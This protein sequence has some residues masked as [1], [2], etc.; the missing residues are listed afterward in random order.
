M[1]KLMEGMVGQI[2]VGEVENLLVSY[3]KCSGAMTIARK[4]EM[5]PSARVFGAQLLS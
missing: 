1:H 5:E 3:R 4:F 2:V